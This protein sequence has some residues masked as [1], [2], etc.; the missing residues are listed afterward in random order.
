LEYVGWSNPVEEYQLLA[1]ARNLPVS[2]WNVSE[3][4]ATKPDFTNIENAADKSHCYCI[5]AIE[6]GTNLFG[7]KDTAYSN[8]L[9]PFSGFDIY[10]PNAFRPRS[11]HNPI[12]KPTGLSLDNH[13]SKLS[14]YTRWGEKVYA[15]F[16][17]DGWDGRDYKGQ[18]APSGAYVYVLEAVDASG[19]LTHHR[20]MVHLLE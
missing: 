17:L 2:T 4:H 12:F 16:L 7:T 18:P 1:G 20:G 19:I 11:P 10:I 8:I 13:L 15:S 3:T 9:C 6:T 14:I 5:R